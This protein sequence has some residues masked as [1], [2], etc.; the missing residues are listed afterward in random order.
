M[1]YKKEK[2]PGLEVNVRTGLYQVKENRITYNFDFGMMANLKNYLQL[3]ESG[4][5]SSIACWYK[6]L[7]M[8]DRRKVIINGGI[9]N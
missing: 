3:Y 7:S 9:E 1:S 8:P 5:H 2:I 4:R 6:S